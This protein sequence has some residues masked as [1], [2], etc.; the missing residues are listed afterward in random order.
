MTKKPSKSKQTKP[1]T[2]E[3]K[4]DLPSPKRPTMPVLE[5]LTKFKELRKYVSKEGEF[6]SGLTKKE[7]AEGQRMV[8][9]L[10]IKDCKPEG[11]AWAIAE[12]TAKKA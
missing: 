7:L 2:D 3:S 4:P 11:T 6:R 8:A 10:N 5:A 9:Q 12:E 1:E